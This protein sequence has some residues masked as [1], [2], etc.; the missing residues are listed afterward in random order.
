MIVKDKTEVEF[1]AEWKKL[2]VP[3]DETVLVA[4]STGCDSMTLLSLLQRLPEGM[5]PTVQVAY[6]DHQLRE[7]SKEETDFIT[8]YCQENGLVLFKSAWEKELHPEKGVEESARKFRYRFFEKVMEETG[9]KYLLTAHHSN[10]QA[11]TILMKAV[12]GGDLEQ[13]AGIR[14]SRTFFNGMLLRPLLHFSKETLK[15]YA[16]RNQIRYFED[17][18]N[19]LDDVLRNRLRHHVMPLLERENRRFLTHVEELSLQ[20]NDLLDYSEKRID[21]DCLRLKV[22]GGYSLEKWRRQDESQK[23]LTLKHILKQAGDFSPKKQEQCVKILEND[24]KPQGSLALG[25]SHAFFRTYGIFGVRKNEEDRQDSDDKILKLEPG[26]WYSLSEREKIGIFRRD[27]INLLPE[28]DVL[29]ISSPDGLLLRHRRCGDV[30]K[31]RGGTQKIKKILIDKKIAL[32]ERK[33]LWLVVNGENQ[34]LWVVG[35]K[36]SDLSRGCVN[37]KIQYIA[38]F[39]K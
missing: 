23:R 11:E 20:L 26:K 29:E 35:V 3:A 13:L 14:A 22:E 32:D 27:K 10:D 12:R 30:L 19:A 1:Q 24:A 36:K 21:D 17:E 8:K 4:V 16:R 34:A 6:V 28:D 38:V 37:A 15:E 7:Q 5:R 18:T 33:K 39:R 2:G 25:D 31:T 9:I